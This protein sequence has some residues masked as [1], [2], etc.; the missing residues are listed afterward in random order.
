VC[1]L[2]L[3]RATVVT[4]PAP[5]PVPSAGR[6]DGGPCGSSGDGGGGDGGPRGT[7]ALCVELVADRF[8]RR[9]AA[10]A[11]LHLAAGERRTGLQPHTADLLSPLAPAPAT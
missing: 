7:R 4:L 10:R 3:A 9:R 8:L 5:G 6:A 1:T 2:H 11:G